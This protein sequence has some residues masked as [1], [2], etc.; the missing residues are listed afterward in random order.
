[1][2]YRSFGLVAVV[3]VLVVGSLIGLLTAAGVSPV[4]AQESVRAPTIPPIRSLRYERTVLLNGQAAEVCRGEFE[5]YNR[6]HVTCR[7]L[8]NFDDGTNSLEAG[9]IFQDVFY[10]GTRYQRQNDNT[11]WFAFPVENY[12]P[13]MTINEGIDALAVL[14]PGTPQNRWPHQA[15][16]L[17][18]TTVNGVPATH[19]QV[20]I[21]DERI[22][23]SVNGQ[24]V[25]DYFLGAGNLP[26]Q[27]QDH[28]RLIDPETGSATPTSRSS[29]IHGYWDVNTPIEVAPPPADLVRTAEVGTP[30][31]S[32][33]STFQ[34]LDW[35]MGR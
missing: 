5:T 33:Q 25:Y 23:Q 9:V 10:D 24:F 7:Q 22:Q 16:S 12:D 32:M 26:V 27:S 2:H 18:S 28:L 15:V 35:Q 6:H 31:S 17:G 21:T 4:Q 3:L 20:W 14:T 34:M 13:N 19:Y 11:I 29:F 30:G 8:I 1:M